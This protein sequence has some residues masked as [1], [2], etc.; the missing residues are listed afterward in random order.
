LSAIEQI[1]EDLLWREAELALLRDMV[2][3]SSL[4]GNKKRVLFRSA[5]AMLY[6]HYEGFCKFCWDVYLE[7]LSTIHS[8]IASL[9]KRTAAHALQHALKKAKSLNNFD[10][11]D[12]IEIGFP[13]E[14]AAAPKFSEIDTKSNL[15]PSVFDEILDYT[16]TKCS[17]IEEQRTKIKTLVARR[18]DIAHGKKVFIEDLVYYLEYESAVKSVMYDL[19]LGIDARLAAAQLQ[20]SAV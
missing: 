15:W 1:E 20:Q 7:E 12:F 16:D 14:I 5:W 18:N 9:P 8:T 19:A 17:A 13:S 6:A 3:D 11:W 2:S 4:R 10:L